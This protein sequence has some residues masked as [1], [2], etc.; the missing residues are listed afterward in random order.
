MQN[1]TPVPLNPVCFGFSG[2]YRFPALAILFALPLF[3]GNW[4]VQ[5][6]PANEVFILSTT[7]FPQAHAHNDYRHAK[8]LREALSRGFAS[9][10]VDVHL[11]GGALYLGHWI[12]RINPNN[13]LQARYLAPLSALMNRQGGKVYP[14]YDGV[15]Y[16]MVD[17]KTGAVATYQALRRELLQFPIF[18]NNPHFRVFISGNR[19]LSHIQND[20]LAVLAVDGRLPDLQRG[21]NPQQMP[22]VSDNF[23]KYFKWQGKGPIPPAEMKQLCA[24]AAETHRQGKML[25]LWSIPDQPNVWETLLDAGVDLIN[26]NNL[27]GLQQ[28]LI[29]R[30]K[31]Q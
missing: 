19:A 27:K 12:P 21:M 7:T 8:P 5:T 30:S 15:F 22:V 17:I 18:Q 20:E 10:E 24:L 3:S 11:I 31:A 14:G 29:A 1:E 9:I 23:R 16:L 2:F 6:T 28:F 25:R 26:T 4:T 13:T